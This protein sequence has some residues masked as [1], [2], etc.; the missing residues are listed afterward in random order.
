MAFDFSKLKGKPVE[1][2]S[3]KG[4]AL[5]NALSGISSDASKK[6]AGGLKKV[7]V[8]S[9]DK[10]GLKAG[11]E[12]AKEIV[13]KDPMADEPEMEDNKVEEICEMAEGMPKDQIQELISKLQEK[14]SM[15]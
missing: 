4:E 2:D 11:L 14:L 5:K 1:K 9:N 13:G 6:I 7:T 15:E 12:K 3:V 10:E 8:A